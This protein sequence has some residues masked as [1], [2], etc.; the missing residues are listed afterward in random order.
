MINPAVAAY[1]EFPLCCVGTRTIGVIKLVAPYE[2]PP[3]FSSLRRKIAC[4]GLADAERRKQGHGYEG[5]TLVIQSE[6]PFLASKTPPILHPSRCS[7]AVRNDFH[8]ERPERGSG[9]RSRGLL[10]SPWTFSTHCPTHNM[11]C[12]VRL[13]RSLAVPAV[14]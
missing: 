2:S 13:P 5:K 10:W 7:P 11:R 6:S 4:R 3:G 14:L 8:P 12:V 1:L 9:N